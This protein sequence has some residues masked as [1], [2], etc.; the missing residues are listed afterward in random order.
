MVRRLKL[1]PKDIREHFQFE[2]ASVFERVSLITP[3]PFW[4]VQNNG[5]YYK[6]FKAY[7]KLIPSG[8]LGATYTSAEDKQY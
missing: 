8:P 2:K 1:I 6:A 7:S 4:L 3:I 5:R